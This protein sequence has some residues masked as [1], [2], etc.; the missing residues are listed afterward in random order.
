LQKQQLKHKIMKKF[1][2]ITSAVFAL[3]VVNELSAQVATPKVRER[4]AKQQSRIQEGRK[5]GELTNKETARLEAQQAKIQHDKRVAKSDGVVTPAERQKL[6][7]EQNR[8]SRNIYR[9]KHDA[10]EK[11]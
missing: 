1:F 5:S 4:Q 3:A 10:Q 11:H 9:Q 6:K 7:R 2:I 8:A